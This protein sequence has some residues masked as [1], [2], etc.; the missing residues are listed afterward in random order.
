[1]KIRNGFV[2]NSSS[3]SFTI[4]KKNLTDKQIELIRDHISVWRDYYTKEEIGRW[5]NPNDA[6][7]DRHNEWNITE[8]DDEIDCGTSMDNF[9]LEDFLQRIGIN[10]SQLEKYYH[11]N[12]FWRDK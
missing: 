12:D 5:N 1:M 9:D 8:T 7:F 11:S 6:T 3:C 10:K 2:S 4:S